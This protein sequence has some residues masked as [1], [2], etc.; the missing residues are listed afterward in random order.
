MDRARR[1]CESRGGRPGR[2]SLIVLVCGT[3][4]VD[5]PRVVTLGPVDKTNNKTRQNKNKIILPRS[6]AADGFQE[7]SELFVSVN[8]KNS[9]LG[10][11]ELC[12][13]GGGRPGLPSLMVLMVSVDVKQHRRQPRFRAEELCE[14]RGGRPGL[15]VPGSP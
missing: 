2:P 12:E 11:R 8:V 6:L 1:L 5:S 3:S 7:Y 9:N 13:S 14:S 10:S 15:P 4:S